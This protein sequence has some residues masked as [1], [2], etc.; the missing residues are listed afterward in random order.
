MLNIINFK[1]IKAEAKNGKN[2][3]NS[4]ININL[5][6]VHLKNILKIFFLKILKK[7]KLNFLNIVLL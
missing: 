3:C 7:P 2:I 4:L 6:I 1:V 5:N